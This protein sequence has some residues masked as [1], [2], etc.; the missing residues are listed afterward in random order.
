MGR[1]AEEKKRVYLEVFE[2]AKDKAGMT[3]RNIDQRF[4]K[5][6]GWCKHKFDKGFAMMSEK[7]IML[8]ALLLNTTEDEL[9]KLPVSPEGRKKQESTAQMDGEV[10]DAIN[11]LTAVI[12]SG[13]MTITK[14]DYVTAKQMNEL[15]DMIRNGF[16]MLHTDMTRLIEKMD[17]YWKGGA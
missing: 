16:K 2:E 1:T 12:T 8:F 15:H 5:S 17:E 10:V 3:W 6:D 9:T 7:D 14:R 4:G 13:L 11:D